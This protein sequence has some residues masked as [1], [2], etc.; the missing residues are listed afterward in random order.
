MDSVVYII[1]G[2]TENVRTRGYRQVIRFFK[3]KHIKPVVVNIHWKYHTMLDYLDQFIAQ[4]KPLAGRK[5]YLFG[6]SF[7]AMVAFLASSLINPD[8]LYLC[9]LSPYFK[10]D[11]TYIKKRGRKALG[12]R[13]IRDFKTIS[14]HDIAKK[15]FCKTILVAGNQES[16]DVL[17]RA[18][19][20]R[21]EITKAKFY[22][23]KGAT[24][25]LSQP[26]YLN[27]LK[28]II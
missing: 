10:E 23:A 26:E 2:Y 21:H 22:L 6:F 24:H 16:P 19:L 8:K 17:R 1:P 27:A 11:L 7:G 28:K 15:V 13:K 3:Q 4:Y 20:A 14:F 25:D 9:S 5:T 12:K 18:Y